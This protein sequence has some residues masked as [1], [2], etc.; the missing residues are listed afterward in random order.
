MKFISQT[1]DQLKNIPTAY[2]RF[3][4]SSSAFL[5]LTVGLIISI[6]TEEFPQAFIVTSLLAGLF[7]IVVQLLYERF[8]TNKQWVQIPLYLAV[9][10][11]LTGYYLYLNQ[12]ELF[13][14]AVLTRLAVLIF[15]LVITAIWLPTIN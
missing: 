4:F 6:A 5:M 13:D 3:L 9:L 2:T 7:G 12:N 10:G 8:F 14:Y 1:Q 11:F 15:M